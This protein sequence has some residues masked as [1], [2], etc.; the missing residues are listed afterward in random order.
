MIPAAYL[1]ATVSAGEMTYL[2]VGEGPAVILLHGYP[3]SSFLWREIAP[4]LSARMR[5][6]AIPNASYPP[7]AEALEFADEI[8]ESLDHLTPERI[9]GT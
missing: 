2:D 7:D 1:R 5:V 6:I 3:T 8:V 9:E 4:V